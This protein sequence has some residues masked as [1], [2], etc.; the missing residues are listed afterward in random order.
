LLGP[1]ISMT[2]RGYTSQQFCLSSTCKRILS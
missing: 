1:F 2:V